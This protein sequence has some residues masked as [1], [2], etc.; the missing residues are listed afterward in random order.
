LIISQKIKILKQYMV[1]AGGEAD[2]SFSHIFSINSVDGL[3][4]KAP[5]LLS[6]LAEGKCAKNPVLQPVFP[7]S[8]FQIRIQIQTPH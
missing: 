7:G 4:R 3:G 2:K 6:G 8:G 5:Y 1:P